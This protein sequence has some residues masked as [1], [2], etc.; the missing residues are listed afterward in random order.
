MGL[1]K[2]VNEVLLCTA[3]YGRNMLTRKKLFRQRNLNVCMFV[4]KVAHLLCWIHHKDMV[5]ASLLSRRLNL[6]FFVKQILQLILL[7]KIAEKNP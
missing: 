3:I 2:S 4:P 5:F 6:E 7:Y 1:N